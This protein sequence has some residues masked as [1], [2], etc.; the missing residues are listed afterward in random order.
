MALAVV[1]LS[2]V[3]LWAFQRSLVYFPDRGEPPS[4]GDVLPGGLDV[5]LTTSDGLH[6]AAWY[7]PAPGSCASTVLLA[8]GNAGNRG[9]R[10]ELVRALHDAGFGVLA[11]DYRGYGG[12]P[13]RPSENGLG[14]DVRAARDFLVRDARVPARS[15]V[16]LGESLGAAVVAELA[17]EHAP[18]ALVLR[19]PFTSLAG[20]GRAAYRVPVGWLLRDR[21]PVLD[22][23]EAIGVPIAVV[24]GSA[25]TIVPSRLSRRVAETAR[26]AGSA[27]VEVD[28]AGAGHNDGALV[29]GRELI[30]ALVEVARLGGAAPCS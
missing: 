21:Y 14:L 10:L 1:M 24:H 22:H 29:H 18:A 16:Y 4:A 20:V 15:I 19:S 7:V 17:T 8:P 28:V 23:V 27:V 13:G 2:V 25:D 3:A 12:N 30:G 9:D 11:L 26:E 6:L 5:V